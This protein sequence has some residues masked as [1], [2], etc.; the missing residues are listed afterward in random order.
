[1]FHIPSR[2]ERSKAT[3]KPQPAQR[4][5]H[6]DA[7]HTDEMEVDA[8]TTPKAIPASVANGAPAIQPE[9]PTPQSAPGDISKALPVGLNFSKAVTTGG[10]G[11][12][13]EREAEDPDATPPKRLEMDTAPSGP[14]PASSATPNPE[15]SSATA[16]AT[17][18]AARET[19]AA[20]AGPTAPGPGNNANGTI[21]HQI[22]QPRLTGPNP[23]PPP[24]IAA[25]LPLQPLHPIN[26]FYLPA[27]YELVPRPE[28]GF[29]DIKGQTYK[30]IR[31]HLDPAT[32]RLWEKQ[33]GPSVIAFSPADNGT[34]D[35]AKVILFREMLRDAIHAPNLFI[36][37]PT[38]MHKTFTEHRLVTPYYIGGM[39]EDQ[40]DLLLHWNCWANPRMVFFIV[41]R[42][43]FVSNFVMTLENTFLDDSDTSIAMVT[44]ALMT[45]IMAD[46]CHLF[47]DFVDENHDAV[48]P[49]WTTEDILDTI[50]GAME[51]EPLQITEK[52]ASITL[53]NIYAASPTKD[54]DAFQFLGVSGYGGCQ[55]FGFELQFVCR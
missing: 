13:R 53:F 42:G 55:A 48:G 21:Y 32:L 5:H 2:S 45:T 7:D 10:K 50:V 49:H 35:T 26:E 33:T 39:T 52:G 16:F 11:K 41:P 27:K 4:Y 36:I 29:P 18:V 15:P 14:G 25:A 40:C 34:V 44:S 9:S 24:G 51:V 31:A 20:A 30:T 46:A 23:I 28:G 38:L 19:P 54:G 1:M 12:K 43:C 6:P 47:E 37:A 17:P 3:L 8:L 22:G